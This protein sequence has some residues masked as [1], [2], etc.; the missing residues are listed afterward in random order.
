MAVSN[1]HRIS[2][3]TAIAYGFGLNSAAF[4]RNQKLPAFTI[5]ASKQE[6]DK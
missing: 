1:Q 5:C 4:G 6:T 3:Q 2:R